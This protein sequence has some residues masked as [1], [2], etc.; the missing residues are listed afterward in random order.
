MLLHVMIRLINNRSQP[1]RNCC[2]VD[3]RRSPIVH[4]S[5]GPVRRR[6]GGASVPT[7]VERHL[8]VRGLDKGLPPPFQSRTKV[9]FRFTRYVTIPSLAT[10]TCCSLTQAPLI[11]RVLETAV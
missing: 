9:T 11:D 4:A 5:G 10:V 1:G 2:R 6:A 8:Q 3:Y 7:M